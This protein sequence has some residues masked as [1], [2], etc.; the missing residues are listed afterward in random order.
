MITVDTFALIRTHTYVLAATVLSNFYLQ[1]R[2]KAQLQYPKQMA[3]MR[4]FVIGQGNMRVDFASNSGPI[5]WEFVA[6]WASYMENLAK[7]GVTG[8]LKCW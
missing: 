6:W 7:R 1:M 3:P 5:T 2:L 4:S 8:R